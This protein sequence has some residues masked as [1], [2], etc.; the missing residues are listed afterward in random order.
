[1]DTWLK[2]QFHVKSACTST[3]SPETTF[4]ARL[5]NV[6]NS[7]AINPFDFFSVVVRIC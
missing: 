3:H 2:A 5:M 1:M 4:A 7:F 6:C